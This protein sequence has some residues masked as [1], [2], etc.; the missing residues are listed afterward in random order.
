MVGTRLF[1]A[2][3]LAAPLLLAQVPTAPVVN[4]R[5]VQN[6]FTLQPAPAVVAAGA[7]LRITGINL[8]PAA[9]ATATGTPWPL[10]L[11][12][13][14]VE[15]IIN[16]RRA[17]LYSVS[18]SKIVCQVPYEIPAGLAQV[19][20]RRGEAT[21]R[22]A[23]FFV[24]PQAASIRT[25]SGDG[26]GPAA[27][28]VEGNTAS[29]T[30]AGLGPTEPRVATGEA[31]AGD[32]PVRPR[33]V[34]VMHLDGIPVEAD[35]RLSASAV[36]VFQARFELPGGAK[37]GD[38]LRVTAGGRP[39]NLVTYGRRGRPQMDFL[40]LPAGFTDVRG[41][42]ISGLRSGYAFLNG[43]RD[44]DGCY[45]SAFFD[46][47]RKTSE[48]IPGCLTGG[49]RN[50]AT[51]FMT[52]GEASA[53]TAF[54]GPAVGQQ[55]AGVSSKLIIFH[56][57]NEK[58]L[59]VTLPEPAANVGSNVEG[60]L[61]AVI[62]GTPNKQIRID[63]ISG[64]QTELPPPTPNPGG[65]AAPAGGGGLN[66][67]NL[68][69]DLGDGLT[70]PLSPPI[71]VG[72]NTFVLVVGDHA[73]APKKA[74]VALINAQ[75]QV[76]G[77]R[78]FPESWL[79]L[80]PPLPPTRPAQPGQPAQPAQ[81]AAQIRL[82]VPTFFDGGARLLYLPVRSS[83]GAKHSIALFPFDENPPRTLELPDG[84]FLTA[85]SQ[86]LPLFNLEL[87]R[88]IAFLGSRT[89]E[90][91]SRAQCPAQGFLVIDLASRNIGAAPLPGNGV[92]NASAA[93]G[94]INDFIFGGNIDPAVQ[95]NS[96]TVYAFDTVA[97]S[98]LRLDLPAGILTFIGLN[99]IPELNLLVGTTRNRVVGDA[100]LVVFDLERTETRIL[101][102][103]EGFNTVNLIGLFPATRKLLARGNREN[104]SV[105]LVYD[106]LTSDLD[107]VPNPS[108]V[109]WVGNVPAAPATPGQP[110]QPTQ[111][112][113]PAAQVPTTPMQRPQASSNSITSIGYGPD[114][115]P[116]GVLVVRLP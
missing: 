105:Y 98:V 92:L 33:A 78:E 10:E 38:V 99:P 70:V 83:D 81:P 25:E 93:S 4:A 63:P 18:P 40:P 20:V 67:N 115:Q 26:A 79:P 59:E 1:I 28:T 54:V 75:F 35:V 77:T 102:T 76:Q 106:L 31:P 107:I 29:L 41:L 47:T 62:P 90:T 89:A 104:G 51:P 16:A 37:P 113:Q 13:P 52:P 86:Q 74:K 55:P 66:L 36:G 114:R 82:S 12:D 109:A 110:G 48:L 73:D 87:T 42:S 11:G 46:L 96:D 27:L 111:P 44:D 9:G 24:N 49:N 72:S 84:W 88:R 2:A 45:R 6:E 39:A 30:L 43:A 3:L 50:A 69:I 34:V 5:G 7:L 65:G 91:E 60:D 57:A 56:P 19:V 95:G 101:A 8:G 103:P 85:C 112:G 53:V 64:E 71:N 23:R 22:P 61:I 97:S 116:A 94:E 32:D 15:V 80:V 68:R 14:P 108:G 100:G 17:P 58:P 21:S